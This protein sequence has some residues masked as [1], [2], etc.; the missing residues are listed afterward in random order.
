MGRQGPDLVQIRQLHPLQIF[1]VKAHGGIHEG[2]A[3]RQLHGH[4]GGGQIA[5][6]VHHQRHAPVRQTSQDLIPVWIEGVA[7]IV[8]MGVEKDRSGL[9]HGRPA[10][11]GLRT[12]STGHRQGPPGYHDS[13]LRPHWNTQ[14]A[15][16]G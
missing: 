5:A 2:P 14:S 16:I 12:D 13:I 15:D 3:L 7:V 11:L 8:G 10:G 6:G 4:P 1:R 9:L